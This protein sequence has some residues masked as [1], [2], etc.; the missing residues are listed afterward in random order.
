V[1]FQT[2]KAANLAIWE[3]IIIMGKNLGERCGKNPGDAE[4]ANCWVP[5]ISQQ[6]VHNKTPVEPEERSIGHL[7]A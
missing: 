4:S 3:G 1:W 5:T 6:D 7:N 2:P